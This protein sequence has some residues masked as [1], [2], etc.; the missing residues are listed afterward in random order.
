VGRQGIQEGTGAEVEA[1]SRVK[2][3]TGRPRLSGA[4]ECVDVLIGGEGSWTVRPI[5]L[6]QI[7]RNP[8]PHL[9]QASAN[10]RDAGRGECR[11]IGRPRQ[12]HRDNIHPN[13]VSA[14]AS[15]LTKVRNLLVPDGPIGRDQVV[16]RAR[17]RDET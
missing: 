10:D 6:T 12:V 8:K 4:T 15:L 1:G 13:G 17:K 5:F 7:E 16:L 14:F 11:P 3:P 2:D 9:I